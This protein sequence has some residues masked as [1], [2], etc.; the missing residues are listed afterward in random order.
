ME[1]E[2]EK[3]NNNNLAYTW[4]HVLKREFPDL[5]RGLAFSTSNMVLSAYQLQGKWKKKKFLDL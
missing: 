5:K 2:K 4:I 3:N 1:L